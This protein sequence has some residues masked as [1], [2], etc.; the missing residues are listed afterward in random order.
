M[1]FLTEED[2]EKMGIYPT[3]AIKILTGANGSLP[4]GLDLSFVG[5]KLVWH[6]NDTEPRI[7]FASAL[8]VALRAMAEAQDVERDEK[9]KLMLGDIFSSQQSNF[10]NEKFVKSLV[11]A[12]AHNPHKVKVCIHT[13][14][15]CGM[16]TVR[17][18][19]YS[20]SHQMDHTCSRDKKSNKDEYQ[21]LEVSKFVGLPYVV[22]RFCV[23][24]ALVEDKKDFKKLLMWA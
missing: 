5:D 20:P 4:P 18:A 23:Y 15:D 2:L 16:V 10:S 11:E 19:K 24:M 6:R 12:V 9:D 8:D 22:Q 17:S 21:F 14:G 13:M 1:D 3:L 7:L